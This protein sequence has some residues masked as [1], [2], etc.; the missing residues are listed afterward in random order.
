MA[1]VDAAVELSASPSNL[2]AI[3]HTPAADLTVLAA[4]AIAPHALGGIHR[5]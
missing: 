5:W 2:S 3:D 4:S 1:S